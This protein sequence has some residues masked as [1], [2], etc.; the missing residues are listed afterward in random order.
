MSQRLHVLFLLYLCDF[1]ILKCTTLFFYS[2]VSIDEVKAVLLSALTSSQEYRFDGRKSFK[3]YQGGSDVHRVLAEEILACVDGLRYMMDRSVVAVVSGMGNGKSRLLDEMK[4]ICFG[5]QDVVTYCLFCDFENDT[6]IK[7]L[8][9]LTNLEVIQERVHQEMLDR[10]MFSL[11]KG[12]TDGPCPIGGKCFE[13]YQKSYRWSF[14]L[15][16]LILAIQVV[17]PNNTIT[18]VLVDGAHRMDPIPRRAVDFNE[19]YKTSY[20]REV[21]STLSGA[22]L[23]APRVFAACSS[24]TSIIMHKLFEDSSLALKLLVTPPTMTRMPEEIQNSVVLEH[25]EAF[26]RLFGEHPRTLEFLVKD[27]SST[28]SDVFTSAAA[29][30]EDRYEL[31]DLSPDLVAFLLQRT[32]T[33]DGRFRLN[34]EIGNVTCEYLTRVGLVKIHPSDL[35]EGMG[36]P[37][38]WYPLHISALLMLI[39][40]NHSSVLSTWRPYYEG[41]DA[42]EQFAASVRCIRSQVCEDNIALKDLHAGADWLK[43]GDT[44]VMKMP[45]QLAASPKKISTKS[46]AEAAPKTRKQKRPTARGEWKVKLCTQPTEGQKRTLTTS[47]EDIHNYTIL[48]ASDAP[49]GDFFCRLKRSN[50]GEHFNEVA[51]CKC[52]SESPNASNNQSAPRSDEMKKSVSRGDAFIMISQHPVAEKKKIPKDIID[53]A[54]VGPDNFHAYFGPLSGTVVVNHPHVESRKRNCHS[55]T[56]GQKI[57]TLTGKKIRKNTD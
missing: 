26:I 12:V 43:G 57:K 15:G 32:L 30:L 44:K 1:F 22:I 17:A 23:C 11:M 37:D 41:S 8:P 4:S 28:L 56:T 18:M 46:C 47:S 42:F 31:D 55:T 38:P 19:L 3:N 27:T 50:D 13:T 49:A 29:A 53:C 9:S 14:N 25:E 7:E 36:R 16:D 40:R 52:K 35:N 48:N 24:S 6:D 54:V 33:G 20:M 10:I 45:M 21:Y 34:E 51:Q 39:Y 5:D 2:Q